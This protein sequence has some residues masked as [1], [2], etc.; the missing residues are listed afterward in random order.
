[1]HAMCK[2][3][4]FMWWVDTFDTRNGLVKCLQT[5]TDTGT[6]FRLL[7]QNMSM[8]W[9]PSVGSIKL[10]VSLSEYCLCYRALLPKRHINT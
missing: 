1:M 9:L 7:M 2:Y 8:G 3:I 4:E 6:T 5:H 10:Y